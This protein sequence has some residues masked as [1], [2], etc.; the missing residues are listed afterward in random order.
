MSHFQDFPGC[1][2][3]V[4]VRCSEVRVAFHSFISSFK[5]EL[6]MPSEKY[7]ITI[8]FVPGTVVGL[9]ESLV[10]KTEI[11]PPLRSLKSSGGDR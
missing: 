10:R 7:L 11:V 6:F 9:R 3:D 8:G 5:T 1:S 4:G 2:R